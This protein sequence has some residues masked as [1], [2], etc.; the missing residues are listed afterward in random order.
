[1]PKVGCEHAASARPSVS[2]EYAPTAALSWPN[3]VDC[4]ASAS[5]EFRR[6]V[7]LLTDDGTGVSAVRPVLFS[8]PAGVLQHCDDSRWPQ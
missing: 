8:S 7:V 5:A 4:R 6:R 2:P 3:A 1:M